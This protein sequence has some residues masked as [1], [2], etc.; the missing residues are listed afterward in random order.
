MSTTPK[1]HHHHTS[2]SLAVLSASA[3]LRSL[4]YPVASVTRHTDKNITNLSSTYIPFEMPHSD[5][6]P[7]TLS[8]G[9]S[10]ASSTASSA[11]PVITTGVPVQFEFA[12]QLAEGSPTHYVSNFA[13][14]IELYEKIAE[15]FDISP[16]EVRTT[17]ESDAPH[18]HSCAHF[19]CPSWVLILSLSLYVLSLS[20]H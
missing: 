13:S 3:L 18:E 17:T 19:R 4:T 10:S 1:D 9:S 12:C 7:P 5:Y 16:K 2:R 20:S 11:S 8:T 14:M 15:C 6:T